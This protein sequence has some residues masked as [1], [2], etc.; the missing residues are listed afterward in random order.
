[1]GLAI[2]AASVQGPRL[3]AQGQDK[4]V[5][6]QDPVPAAAAAALPQGLVV[7]VPPVLFMS[8]N[9]IPKENYGSTTWYK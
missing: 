9:I 1:V 2:L 6:L 4:M 3:E 7:W 5:Q 8:L